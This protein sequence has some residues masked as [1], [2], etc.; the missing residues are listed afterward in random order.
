MSVQFRT[1]I[2]TWSCDAAYQYSN[3]RIGHADH[4]PG[5][6]DEFSQQLL[7]RLRK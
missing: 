5:V 2:L 4:A 1:T 3:L 6:H 7:Q